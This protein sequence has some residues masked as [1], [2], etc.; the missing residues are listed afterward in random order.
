[1]IQTNLMRVRRVG[2]HNDE[3]K[4]IMGKEEEDDNDINKII[5]MIL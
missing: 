4:R 3:Y 2:N 1:M 5:E